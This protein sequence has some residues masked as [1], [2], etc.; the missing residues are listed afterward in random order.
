[1]TTV[2]VRYA[3]CPDHVARHMVDEHER[4]VAEGPSEMKTLGYFYLRHIGGGWYE[5]REP[6][7]PSLPLDWQMALEDH[8]HVHV[9]E[10]EV[11]F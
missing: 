2:T 11:D 4:H 8:V 7:S 9:H 3:Y 6:A 10:L 1:M 5:Y